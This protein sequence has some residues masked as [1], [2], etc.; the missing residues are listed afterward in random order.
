MLTNHKEDTLL[1]LRNCARGFPV[2]LARAMEIPRTTA[3]R[4]IQ[5]LEEDGIVIDYTPIVEPQT[6][7]SPYLIQVDIDPT[8]YK[9]RTDLDDT[10]KALKEYL[11][12]GIAHAS[13]C[14]Y[15]FKDSESDHIQVHC[16]T[17]TRNIDYLIDAI[18]HKQNIARENIS[19]TP[20]D[21]AD[22]ITNYSKF[23]LKQEV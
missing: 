9:I 2:A 8:D 12:L 15:Y 23:S 16:I 18:Y 3:R 20:L 7:G 13:M 14:F 11:N 22:G 4:R 17:M 5:V 19:Y 1:A 10:V 6:F 21:E